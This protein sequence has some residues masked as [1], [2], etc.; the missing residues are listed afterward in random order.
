M[1]S[2]SGASTRGRCKENEG[3]IL[4]V[5]PRSF[6]RPPLAILLFGFLSLSFLF[7]IPAH[8]ADA[9][10]LTT[11]QI[12][13]IIGLLQSFGADAGVV[14]N[15][16]KNLGVTPTAPSID[17]SSTPLTTT[18]TLIRGMSGA[19]VTQ[20]QNLL[21]AQ[22]L[23][24]ADSATG[25]FGALTE[26]AVQAFQRKSNIASS[27]TP[28]TTGY[29]AVGP[30][31]R[32]M[33][34][35]VSPPSLAQ[36][37][38]TQTPKPATLPMPVAPSMPSGGGGS[39][40]PPVSTPSPASVPSSAVT[41]A[42]MRTPPQSSKFNILVDVNQLDPLSASQA[43][44]FAGDGVW[45][46]IE[47]STPGVNWAQ[48]LS[49]LHANAWTIAENNPGDTKETDVAVANI[50]R[51]PDGNM[52]YT[53]PLARPIGDQQIATYAAHA[54]AGHTLDGH[55]IV[56][57]R[58]YAQGD[59]R[60]AQ[61]DHALQSPSVSGAAFEF[62]P[63]TFLP[64]WDLGKGC[65][66]ILSLH[67]QCYL[68]MPASFNT[69]NYTADIERAVA[70]FAPFG[71]LTNPNTFIV[72]AAYSLSAQSSIPFVSGNSSDQNNIQ[73]AVAWLKQY[74]NGSVVP[75]TT[76]S[77]TTGPAVYARRALV[78]VHGSA[79]SLRSNPNSQDVT[80]GTLHPGWSV[81]GVGDFN[82]DGQADVFLQNDR[83]LAVWYLN[84]SVILP[85]SGNISSPLLPGWN[86]VGIGDFNGDGQADVFLQNDRQLAVWYL[87]GL[88]VSA[89]SQSISNALLP[90]WSVAG[91]GD[92]NGD[93]TSDLLLK[94]AA[95]V[96]IW[97]LR[98]TTVSNG[99]GTLSMQAAE[100]PG[101]GDFNGD[102]KA[103][104]L[105]Q[106]SLQRLEV[107]LMDGA[108]VRGNNATNPLM[109]NSGWSVVQT[110]DYNGD[111]RTD[112]LLKNGT[113]LAVWNMNGLV[114]SGGVGSNAT[115][116][117]DSSWSLP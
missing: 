92:F 13:A 67:K 113:Q 60:R 66:Y 34:V 64:G 48:T 45:S 42:P 35:Q 47:N 77:P 76:I 15:V 7:G 83:Q 102:G 74:Q 70:Y 68:L 84:G 2:A 38:P 75:D 98:G 85:V 91:I 19:D 78:E 96:A 50:G 117:P 17:P 59:D 21:I 39:V 69:Q 46:I 115:P 101:I 40:L 37:A 89:E 99:S 43:A 88:S 61:L 29:G 82:G 32:G 104:I 56:M 41:P 100:I 107:W 12:Q 112:I 14:A 4:I 90:G 53:E 106:N 63:D 72:V 11:A 103:D 9:S 105:V 114:T 73:S 111:G 49:A 79:V 18:R 5:K 97:F 80:V 55:I 1:Y 24:A 54:A 44:N 86:P 36:T 81:V 22:H 52:F 16:Q 26:A 93:E 27:G 6:I 62:N 65:A 110:G 116:L 33:I 3:I 94:N 8:P 51:V 109:L 57:T 71:V 87:N 28:E 30:K 95:Q 25:Y 23:L 58:T 10:S 31:T 108:S 20:L